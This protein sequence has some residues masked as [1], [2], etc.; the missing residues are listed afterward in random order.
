MKN[1]SNRYFYEVHYTVDDN[2]KIHRWNGDVY[3]DRKNRLYKTKMKPNDLPEY[4]CE[5]QR[6][7]YRHDII[8]ASGVVDIAYSWVKENHFMKDSVLRISYTGNLEPYY[9]KY[10]FNGREVV[11]FSYIPTRMN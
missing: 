11:S 4:Y 10:N 1:L 5:V 7:G 9:E 2:G 8:N 6:Y 3:A